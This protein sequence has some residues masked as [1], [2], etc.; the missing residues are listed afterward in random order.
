MGFYNYEELDDNVIYFFCDLSEFLEEH[1]DLET[2]YT[3]SQFN[4]GE[5]HRIITKLTSL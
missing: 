5:P 4:E 2:D 3:V 1:N